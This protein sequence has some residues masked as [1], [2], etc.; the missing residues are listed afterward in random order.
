M[1]IYKMTNKVNGKIYI[2]QTTRT[3]EERTR[4]HLRHDSIIIDKALKKHGLDNFLIEEIDQAK[5]IDELN[6]KETYYINFYNSMV[7]NGYNQCFGGSNSLGFKHRKESRQ[8]MSVAK[9]EKYK[10]KGNPF[11]GK[12][13]NEKSKEKMREKRKGLAHLDAEQVRKLRESHYTRPVKNLDTNEVFRSIKE[14]AEKYKIE[15]THITRVCKGK[16]KRT[17]GYRWVYFD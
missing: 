6:E 8:K 10:G 16:R 2:G 17:G 1:I 12:R 15:P 7:P 5:T 13:H 14:A 3:L 4:E 11:Y 9:R